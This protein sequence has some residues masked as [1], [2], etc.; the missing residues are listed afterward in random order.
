MDSLIFRPAIKADLPILL[1]FEQGIISYERP[2]NPTIRAKDATY[3]DI[4]AFIDSPDAEVVVGTVNGKIIASGY[5]LIKPAAPQFKYKTYVHLGFMFV[6][7]EY[8]GKGINRLL[9]NELT[10]WSKKQGVLEIRLQVYTE[11]AAA[12]RAYEK[13]GFNKLMVEMRLDLNK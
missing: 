5:A 6:H 7:P 8:R 2:F 4:G 11:N 3:Y 9:I 1:E 13:V 12:V 10:N